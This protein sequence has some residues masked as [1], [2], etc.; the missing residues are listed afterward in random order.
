MEAT[1]KLIVRLTFTGADLGLLPGSPAGPNSTAP[2]AGFDTAAALLGTVSII[3]FESAP[4][5][6]VALTGSDDVDG[7]MT[8]GAGGTLGYDEANRMRSFAPVSGGTEY[9]GYSPET[10]GYTG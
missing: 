1:L 3:N 10:N 5:H 6:G 8:S 7:N 9:Y 2:A 4:V